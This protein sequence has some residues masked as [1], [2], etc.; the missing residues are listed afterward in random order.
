MNG[1]ATLGELGERRILREI[2]PAYTSG[3]GDDCAAIGTLKGHIVVTTDP[4]PTP[5]ARAIAGDEDLYWVGWLLATINAS[6]I[7][8]AGAAPV[9]FLAALEMPE[10]LRVADFHRL[11]AGIRDSCKVNGLSYV[12]G[13]LREA[14]VLAGTGTAIGVS[15]RPPL[16]R[17]GAASGD[18]LVVVG[19]GGRFWADAERI[20]RGF[21]VD[22]IS[23][24][25]YAP[26][27]QARLMHELHQR[28]LVKCAMDSSD[29]LAPTLQE[30]SR[31]NALGLRIELSSMA[32]KH[33]DLDPR[34]ERFW[35]GWGD[36]TIAAAISPHKFDEVVNLVER[37]GG[38]ATSIGRFFDGPA[39]VVLASSNVTLPLGRL[40]SERFAKDSWFAKGVQ[41]YRRMLHELPLP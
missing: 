7:A 25:L 40:E 2:I 30:L 5:A 24:P 12:G 15:A 22:R 34:P 33:R 38:Q 10:S 26:V 23:S 37:L 18:H 14:D 29:G 1:D 32:G 35:L 6:D 17:A 41:E 16:T 3:A 4:V 27:S 39:T 13:N 11:L 36:W 8:A 31:V 21:P 9:G 20:R 19:E 28:A